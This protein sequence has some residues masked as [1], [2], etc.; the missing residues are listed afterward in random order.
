[1][2]KQRSIE[3]EKWRSGGGEKRRRG[4]AE[5]QRNREPG[6]KERRCTLC[7]S[8]NIKDANHGDFL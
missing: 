6:S 2:V 3:A 7:G 8:D 1:M 4:E 5:K